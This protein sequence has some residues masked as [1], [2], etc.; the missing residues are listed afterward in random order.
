MRQLFLAGAMIAGTF[1]AAGQTN[2]AP[3]ALEDFRLDPARDPNRPAVPQAAGPEIDNRPAVPLPSAPAETGATPPPRVAPTMNPTTA[4]PAARTAIRPRTDASPTVPDEPDMPS[5]P[6]MPSPVAGGPVVPSPVPQESSALPSVSATPAAPAG[7]IPALRWPWI[8]GGMLIAG[9]LGVLLLRK[10]RQASS[11]RARLSVAPE[12]PLAQPSPPA[13]PRAAVPPT[14]P[15][16]ATPDQPA[17]P[18]LSV[19]LQFT[20]L[21]MRTTPGGAQLAYRLALRNISDA[22]IEGLAVSAFIAN[23]DARQPQA[24]SAFYDD[25]FAPEAHRVADLAPGAAVAVEGLL[26]LTGERLTPIAVQGRA[27]LIPIVAFRVISLDGDDMTRGAFIVGQEST[28]PAARMAPFR[29][30]QG[31]RAYQGLGCRLAQGP[32]A[33]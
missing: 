21:S 3:P 26:H 9:M 5:P 6:V 33:A 25:P 15:L 30:D 13:K 29:L 18:A 23:A 28:P 7:D 27:L 1:P 20:P 10:R 8:V 12:A 14:P 16:P 19:A 4:A 2:D 22:V 32:V 17:G 31:P 11:R 24:L